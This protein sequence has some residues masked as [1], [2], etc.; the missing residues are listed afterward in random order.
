MARSC[1]R[2]IPRWTAAGRRQARNRSKSDP[3]D[4]QAIAMLVLRDA[5]H[6]PR[7]GAEDQTVLLDLW[8][9]NAKPPRP[10]PFTC[11]VMCTRCFGKSIRSAH[12]ALSRTNHPEGCCRVASVRQQ[13]RHTAKARASCC[14]APN[15]STAAA[16]V[17]PGRRAHHPHT[18]I[19]DS[20][21]IGTAHNSCAASICSPAALQVAETTIKTHVQHVLRKLHARNRAEAAAGFH[22]GDRR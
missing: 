7:V 8:S 14:R 18:G 19:G 21:W 4:A 6:L 2:S 11:A 17:G 20:V 5:A 22:S 16:C 12:G 15:G 1:S 9:L 3:L 13:H 10:R